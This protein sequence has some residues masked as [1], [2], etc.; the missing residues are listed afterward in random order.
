MAEPEALTDFADP[1]RV[2]RYDP[3]DGRYI[4]FQRASGGNEAYGV[5]TTLSFYQ[6]LR[7]NGYAA[8]TSTSGLTG[9]QSSHRAQ[10]DYN[11]DRYGLQAERLSVGAQFNPEVGFLRR[12]G[13][14]RDYALARFSPRPSARHLKGVRRFIYQGSLEYIEDPSG[15]VDTRE[16]QGQFNLEMKNFDNLNLRYTSTY[17]FIPRPF[18]IASGVVKMNLLTFVLASVAARLPRFFVVAWLLRRYGAPK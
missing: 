9:S 13:F 3:R 5:D 14:T 1:V 8:W 18:T 4:V 16:A 2:G 15:R 7:F 11:A 17:E 12:R 10:L 6:N